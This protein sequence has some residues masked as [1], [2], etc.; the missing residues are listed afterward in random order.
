[1]PTQDD[2]ADLRDRSIDCLWA[3][4]NLVENAAIGW[5]PTR[6]C[7]DIDQ[8]AADLLRKDIEDHADSISRLFLTCQSAERAWAVAYEPNLLDAIRSP[9]AGSPVSVGDRVYA[10]AHEAAHELAKLVQTFRGIASEAA[11]SDPDDHERAWVE[12]VLGLIDALPDTQQLEAAIQ[13][14]YALA[15]NATSVTPIPSRTDE[16]FARALR[17]SVVGEASTPPAKKSKGGRPR[18]SDPDE[19]KRLHD[20]WVAIRDAGQITTYAEAAHEIGVAESALR[21]AYERHRKALARK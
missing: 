8:W 18:E 21:A 20:R 1:M 19:D 13:H 9:I 5:P 10:S 7:T 11:E 3:V 12:N 15:C 2:F 17:V 6:R 14:E 4:Q 16:S